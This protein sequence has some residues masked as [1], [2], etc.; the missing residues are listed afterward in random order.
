MNLKQF[1]PVENFTLTT[2][3]SAEEV[4]NRIANKIEPKKSFRMLLFSTSSSKP[5][6]GYVNTGAFKINR[7]IRYKN[8]FLP[9]IEG[10]IYSKASK[11]FI[12]IEMNVL[13]WVVAIVIGIVGVFVIGGMAFNTIF[14]ANSKG[15]FPENFIFHP[16]FIFVLPLFFYVVVYFSF[17]FESK[18]SKYFLAT[19]L[20][21][22]EVID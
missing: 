11:T 1:L 15:S 8:S 2:K 20:E 12:K 22:E 17:K 14:S 5:Y 13:K 16:L 3:L 18:K 19:L 6:E 4:C 9:L 21:G 7:I 10:Q